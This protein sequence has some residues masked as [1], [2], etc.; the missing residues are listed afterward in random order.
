MESK[1]PSKIGLGAENRITW[2]RRVVLFRAGLLASNMRQS[3]QSDFYLSPFFIIFF[4]R[5]DSPCETTKPS[6][7][8]TVPQNNW[9][10]HSF[11]QSKRGRI[12]SGWNWGPHCPA[13]ELVEQDVFD[14]SSWW[15]IMSSLRKRGNVPYFL[16]CA[17]IVLNSLNCAPGTCATIPFF[18]ALQ[19]PRSQRFVS[20]ISRV[21]T[22]ATHKT[23][24]R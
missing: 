4:V 13:K 16:G 2:R 24:S 19:L 22:P 9:R 5:A 6:S 20:A 14:R 11:N 1:I 23:P 15:R 12:K 3:N 7:W 10:P 18:R 8:A 21:H 17:K